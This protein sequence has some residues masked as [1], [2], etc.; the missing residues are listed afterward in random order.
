[1]A[2]TKQMREL[3]VL[4]LLGGREKEENGWSRTWLMR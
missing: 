2:R 3:T 1:M 4:G